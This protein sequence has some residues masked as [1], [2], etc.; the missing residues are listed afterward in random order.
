VTELE[1]RADAVD[2]SLA[3]HDETLAN[4]AAIQTEL[5][6]SLADQNTQLTAQMSYQV[7]LLRVVNYLSRCRLYLSQSNFGLAREDALSAGPCSAACNPPPRQIR[8]TPSMKP[9]TVSIW[10]WP[11]YPP[12][13]WSPCM[14]SILPGS[15]WL[16]D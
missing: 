1:T 13:R 2:K 6:Q 14:T 5:K 4:L 9:S 7:D 3:A 11:I 16:M 10:L 15:T 8:L 12:I